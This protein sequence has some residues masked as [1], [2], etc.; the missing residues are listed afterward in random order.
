M[1]NIPSDLTTKK[2]IYLIRHGETEYNK[3]GIIQ[4]SGINSDLNETG[5]LQA[6]LFYMAYKHIAFDRIYISELNRTYQSVE[7]FIESGVKHEKLPEL[8]EINWGIMEGSIP[9]KY[10]QILYGRMIEDWKAGFL[11]T[12]IDKG[13]SPNEMFRR[14]QAGLQK[15]MNREQEQTV[16]ICMH[17]RAIRSF[18]CLLLNEPLRQMEEFKHSNLCLYV[19]HQKEDGHFRI[20][21]ENSTEHLW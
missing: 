21:I 17:G 9:T 12:A 15:I 5:K 7:P 4:G 20:A 18:L 8:N 13:E 10:N 6:R 1:V 3:R 11:D 19:L 16:L 14:Q 2:T